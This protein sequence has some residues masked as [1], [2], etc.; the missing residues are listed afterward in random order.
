MGKSK[1]LFLGA[2]VVVAV[3]AIAVVVFFA[4]RADAPDALAIGDRA[5]DETAQADQG[6]EPAAE[7]P[8]VLLDDA[9]GSWTLTGDSV[10]G[11]RVVEDF[12]GGIADFEAVGRSSEITGSLAIDGSILSAAEFSID[13]A[14]I[15]GADRMRNESFTGPIM[16]AAMYP[17]AEFV[18][19][20]PVDLGDDPTGGELLTVDVTGQLTCLLYTSPS[21]RD[22]TLSRMPSSA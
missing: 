22:A 11:Y 19:T 12:V 13:V 5:G 7:T 18:L 1:K 17:T 10:A 16:N 9:T 3:V 2:G 20:A 4:T 14:S 8:Q 6:D 15:E 21:P